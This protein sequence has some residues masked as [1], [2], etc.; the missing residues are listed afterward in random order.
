MIL[1]LLRPSWDII[2]GESAKMSVAETDLQKMI[3]SYKEIIKE[4]EANKHRY[5]KIKVKAKGKADRRTF[6]NIIEG[7]V[8]KSHL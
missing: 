7:R 2:P 8:G 6:L 3:S 5:L 4:T 1:F